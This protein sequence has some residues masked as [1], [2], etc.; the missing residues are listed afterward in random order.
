MISGSFIFSL[1][2]EMRHHYQAMAISDKER[3]L[4]FP[5]KIKIWES[6][7][8]SYK[9]NNQPGYDDQDIELDANAFG[10]LMMNLL[11]DEVTPVNPKKV[12]IELLENAIDRIADVYDNDWLFDLAEDYNLPVSL[13]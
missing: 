3:H 4:E 11:F 1:A 2:H 6:E 5:E 7:M 12:N 13:G 10:I 8:L 9:E